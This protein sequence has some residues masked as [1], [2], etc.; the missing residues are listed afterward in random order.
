MSVDINIDSVT[1]AFTETLYWDLHR[2]L[3]EYT[4]V[5]FQ[6]NIKTIEYQKFW[7]D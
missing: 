7:I 3:R 4:S 5:M 1:R 2:M 6:S